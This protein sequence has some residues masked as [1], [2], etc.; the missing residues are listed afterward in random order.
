MFE[1]GPTEYNSHHPS[2]A[3]SRRALELLRSSLT[4]PYPPN[5]PNGRPLDFNLE[6]VEYPPTPD[7]LST[8]MSYL[9]PTSTLSSTFVSTAHP[10]SA[11][12]GEHE[13]PRDP[14]SL[15]KLASRNP[16]S[17][18]WP[19]VVDWMGGR[20]SVGD[21]DGVKAML[22]ALQHHR[23]GTADSSSSGQSES[24]LDK[25]ANDPVVKHKGWFP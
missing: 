15:S 8:I 10:S 13:E 4:S 7:Q 20:A 11:S 21:V 16:S 6:V 2:S 19:I 9:P 1:L 5:Q 23:D 3:T 14:S 24:K 17:I 22:D 18:K 25:L 12:I